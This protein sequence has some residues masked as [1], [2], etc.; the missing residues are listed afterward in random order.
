MYIEEKPG[1]PHMEDLIEGGF[2]DR[3]GGPV[4]DGWGNDFRIECKG[5]DVLVI[6]AGR[7]GHFGSDDI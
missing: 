2:I 5:D 1:C 7:D 3:L 6:S 4:V